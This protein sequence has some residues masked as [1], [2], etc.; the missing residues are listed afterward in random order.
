MKDTIK[1]LRSS[2]IAGVTEYTGNKKVARGVGDPDKPLAVVNA[3]QVKAGDVYTSADFNGGL[4]IM[5]TDRIDVAINKSPFF[6][7]AERTSFVIGTNEFVFGSSGIVLVL[8]NSVG[9]NLAAKASMRLA[10]PITQTFNDSVYQVIEAFDTV[11]LERNGIV[12]DEIA[13]SVT[14]SEDGNYI[15]RIGINFEARGSE[16][17]LVMPYVNSLPMTNNPLSIQGN[18]AGKPTELF[19]KSDKIFSAGDTITLRGKNGDNG[20]VDVDITRTTFAITKDS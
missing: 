11:I 8:G 15:L 2:P 17:L 13:N 5:L 19:W 20:S 6:P 1:P 3:V 4:S 16:E 12:A 18:G 14:V 9:S 10:S 7:S